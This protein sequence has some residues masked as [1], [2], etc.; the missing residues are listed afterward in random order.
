MQLI[1]MRIDPNHVHNLVYLMMFLF[2]HVYFQSISYIAM[3][4]STINI[5]HSNKKC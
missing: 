4:I 3:R 1:L 5:S 2:M